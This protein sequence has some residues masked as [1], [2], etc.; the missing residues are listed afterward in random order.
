MK[1]RKMPISRKL[2]CIK[3]HYS[4][5]AYTVER[6]KIKKMILTALFSALMIVGAYVKIPNPFFPVF[7]TLQGVFCAFA[8]LLL[9]SKYGAASVVIYIIM[10]LAGLPV[11]ST[12]AGPHYV[13]QPTFGF[14]IGFA[15]A[16]YIIG[17]VSESVKDFTTALSFTASLSGLV[18]IYLIGIS[19]MYIIYNLHMKSPT[20]YFALVSSMS[21]YFL[22]DLI[23]FV[24]V[25]VSSAKIKKRAY[26]FIN[27]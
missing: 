11:F 15:A 3:E 26:R 23:L 19:Y 18:A 10:G 7:F 25:A 8:G 1:Y 21:L 14:I 22:K 6:I 9:G 4:V 17:K 2:F 5:M 27:F 20:G 24:L 12:T 16:A 13:L